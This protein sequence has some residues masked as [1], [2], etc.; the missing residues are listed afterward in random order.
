MNPAILVLIGTL[1][2]AVASIVSVVVTS[3]SSRKRTEI[4]S[5]ATPYEALS[6]R[7]TR[8]EAQIDDMRSELADARDETREMRRYAELLRK[9][10]TDQ[11][12]PPPPD[13]PIRK[14]LP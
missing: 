8:L 11:L 12:P 5:R 10:I 9:H 14:E 7:V 4:E 13:W 3:Q 1:S 2:T 6:E